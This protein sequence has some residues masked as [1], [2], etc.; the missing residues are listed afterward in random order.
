MHLEETKLIA[1]AGRLLL[2]AAGSTAA[3]DE[4]EVTKEESLSKFWFSVQ[5]L[6]LSRTSVFLK[7]WALHERKVQLS[8]QSFT[9]DLTRFDQKNPLGSLWS[10]RELAFVF[11]VPFVCLFQAHRQFVS[12]S[13]AWRCSVKDTF[14]LR[15]TEPWPRLPREAVESPSL[16]IFQ[17]G[18]NRQLVCSA[19]LAASGLVGM[20]T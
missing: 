2:P 1:C 3:L 6:R 10:W 18:I 19:G 15:V 17:T 4:R 9:Y 7:I 5:K 16:E 11:S 14:T 12:P 8:T 13:S 20:D